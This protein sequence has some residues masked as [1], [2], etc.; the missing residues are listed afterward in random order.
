MPCRRRCTR[1]RPLGGSAAHHAAVRRPAF[2]RQGQHCAEQLGPG[3]GFEL[4]VRSFAPLAHPAAVLDSFLAWLAVGLILSLT[5]VLTGNI[6]VA[7]GLHGGWVVVL[8]ML[9]VG[10][11]RGDAL[12]LGR[13]LRRIAGLLAVPWAAAIGLALWFTRASVGALCARAEQVEP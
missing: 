6:A 10:T 12:G 13:T 4:L 9:Q 8:R 5:R 3:S 1:I 7:I 11:V 2:L